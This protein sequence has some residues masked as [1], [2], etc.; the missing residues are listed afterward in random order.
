M[1]QTQLQAALDTSGYPTVYGSF[2]DRVEP[3]YIVFIRP[4]ADTVS[5][6]Y[7]VHGKYQNYNIELY[8]NKK[9]LAAEKK[10]EDIIGLIDPE[11]DTLETYIDT[12]KMYQ[13]TYSITIFEK[14]GN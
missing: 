3:P 14:V 13:V 10:L 9:D 1:N 7:K 4:T 6:D 8:T 12:E 5:S 2:K 11:Y